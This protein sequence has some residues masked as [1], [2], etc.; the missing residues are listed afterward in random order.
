MKHQPATP[1][2][3]KWLGMYALL[4]EGAQENERNYEGARRVIDAE[5]A[6]HAANAYPLAVGAAKEVYRLLLAKAG[7]GE[8]TATERT[9]REKLHALLRE[10][11]EE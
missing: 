9:A 6:V 10:L 4:L 7:A 8:L 1:L 5:F 11:G 3:W 2:P